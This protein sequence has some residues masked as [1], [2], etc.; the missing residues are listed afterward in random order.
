V[1]QNCVKAIK[2]GFSTL[3]TQLGSVLIL[4]FDPEYLWS[5][6][7]PIHATVVNMPPD[8]FWFAQIQM[9]LNDGKYETPCN[10]GNRGAYGD[11]KRITGVNNE[12]QTY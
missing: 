4:D 12:S 11:V 8:N 6:A 10:R 3:L 7:R 1:C 5:P 9:G 2:C